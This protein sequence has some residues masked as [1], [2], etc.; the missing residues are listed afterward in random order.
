MNPSKIA[1][2]S[3]FVSLIIMVCYYVYVKP[4]FVMDNVDNVDNDKKKVLSKRLL[5]L[6]SLLFSS[7]VGLLVLGI[8]SIMK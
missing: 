3:T 8:L 1:I 6:Y 7:I 4:D 5:I 2:L